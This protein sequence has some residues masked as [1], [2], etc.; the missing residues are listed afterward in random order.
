MRNVNQQLRCESNLSMRDFGIAVDK[1]RSMDAGRYR[2]LEQNIIVTLAGCIIKIGKSQPERAMEAKSYALRIFPNNKLLAAINISARESCGKSLAGLGARGDA[3]ICRDK[4]QGTTSGPALVVIPGSGSIQPFAMGKY[5]VSVKEMNQFCNATKSCKPLVSAD[6]GFPATNIQIDTAIEFTR[7]LSHTTA[8]KYRLPTRS[9]W[10]HAANATNRSHDPNRNCAFST[11][12]I[13]K[14]GQ[15]VR[16]TVGAQNG[17]GLVNY[18]GNSQE[19]VYDKSRNVVAV[20][21]SYSD[22]MAQCNVDS[23]TNHSG[24]PDNKTGFRVV[25]EIAQ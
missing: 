8:Q 18:L 11:H 24:K 2:G 20:G 17:W 19:W 7:W 5:E 10:V 14:G 15:L 25:R 22:A 3:A 6:D 4:I 23:V 12:G 1:L 16:V 13:E 9:E 21:G